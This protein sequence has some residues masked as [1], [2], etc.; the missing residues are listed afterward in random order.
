LIELSVQN[1][2]NLSVMVKALEKKTRA[3]TP[4]VHKSVNDLYCH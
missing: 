3:F 4:N 2:K 1:D